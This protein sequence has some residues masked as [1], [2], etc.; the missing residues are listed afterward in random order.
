MS[1]LTKVNFKIDLGDVEQSAKVNGHGQAK[2]LSD[3]ELVQLFSDGLTTLRDRALFA[4][5]YFTGSRIGETCQ[6]RCE[7]M[8]EKLITFRAET[9]KTKTTRQVEIPSGLVPFLENYRVDGEY[10]FPGRHGRGHL[11]RAGADLILRRACDRIGLQ[12][13][14]T[15]SFRR[16]YITRLRDKGYSPAQIQR[17]T[18][19]KQRANLLHYFDQV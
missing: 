15:H 5:C 13:V 2:I 18:G 1:P 17:R 19:H 9:T 8:G 4:I 16:T 3:D 6:L 12:G 14:S 10:L 11:T 7:D